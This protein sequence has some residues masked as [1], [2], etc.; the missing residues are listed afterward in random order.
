MPQMQ[1]ETLEHLVAQIALQH[2]H[3]H[4]LAHHFFHHFFHHRF[5]AHRY[6]L[7]HQR[8]SAHRYSLAHQ[9]FSAHHIFHL[10]HPL[11]LDHSRTGKINGSRQKSW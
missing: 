2:C 4:S 8:F 5:S 7:A 9:R 1:M 10:I 11:T 3:H 6:S